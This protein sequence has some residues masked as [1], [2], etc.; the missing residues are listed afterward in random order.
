LAIR[1]AIIIDDRQVSTFGD[2][3]L[4]RSVG[5]SARTLSRGAYAC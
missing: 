2:V 5:V 4:S 3:G 1:P